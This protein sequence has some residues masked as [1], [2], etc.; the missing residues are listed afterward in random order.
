VHAR[1][2]SIR[3]K[4]LVVVDTPAELRVRLLGGLSVDGV[5]EA[6]FGSRKARLLLKRL[7]IERGR[8]VPSDV[9]IETLWNSDRPA[10]PNDQLGVLVSRLRRVVG[11]ERLVHRASG[12]AL[13]VDWLD[14]DELTTR[15]E[16]AA[17]ASAAGRVSAARS[18][19][20][21]AIALARGGVLPD[22]DGEWLDAERAR[23]DAAI[24]RAHQLVAETALLAGDAEAAAAAAETS[25][26]RDPYDEAALRLLM[27][28]HAA[29]GRPAS[30]LAA[31]VRVRARLAEDLGVDPTPET[32]RLH[33][34]LVLGD[35]TLDARTVH[36]TGKPALFGRDDELAVLDG[37]LARARAGEAVAITVRGEGGIGKSTLVSAWAQSI[38]H[39]A[40]VL[41]CRCDPL[42]RDLPLQPVVDAFARHLD[43]LGPV[44]AEL[45]GDDSPLLAGLLGT[46]AAGTPSTVGTDPEV[47]RSQLFA[48]LLAVVER[49][50]DG[51][52]V[53]IIDDIHHGGTS[54]YEWLSFA[55]R[56]G[57]RLMLVLTSRPDGA[58]LA[59]ADEIVLGPLD[60]E[61]VRS[62]LRD[63]PDASAVDDIVARSAG[64]P[65]FARSLA[66]APGSRTPATIRE[67][68]DRQID[69]LGP[70]AATIR[71][72]S[73]VGAGVDVDL[74]AAVLGTPVGDVLDDLELGC[75]AGLLDEG[76]VGFEFRHELVRDALE[77]SAG[78]ARRAHV[79]RQV[80]RALDRRLPR[81]HLA[82]AV[83]ARLGGDAAL[84]S[85]A[86]VDAARMAFSRFDVGASLDHLDAALALVPSADVYG[87]RARVRLAALDLDGAQHDASEAVALGGGASALEVAAW[88]AYYRRR[89]EEARQ[90]ADAGTEVTGDPALQLSC[91][92]VGGRVRHSQGDLAGAEARLTGDERAAVELRGVTDV[93]LAMVRVHQ[94]RPVEALELAERALARPDRLTHA[95]ALMHGRLGRIMAL[96]Q[97]GRVED[98]L[99]S[100]EELEQ[101]LVRAGA[102]GARFDGITA[103]CRGWLLRNVGCFELADESNERALLAH[104]EQRRLT[105]KGLTEA[106]WVA[107]LDLIDGK[108]MAGDPGAAERLIADLTGLET[109]QGTMAW[110]Q[111]QRLVLARAR[112]RAMSDDQRAAWE[113]AEHVR[114]DAAERGSRRYELLAAAV[115]AG[116]ERDPD[117]AAVDAVIAGLEACAKLEGWRLAADLGRQFGVDRWRRAAERMAAD[118]VANAG[119]H[120]DTASAWID[121]RLTAAW[122]T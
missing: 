79:H 106:Y 19:A 110:H 112:A 93:W 53:V 49:L 61:S 99:V 116:C 119:G 31:Y 111:R 97:L 27:R 6:A 82:V 34:Q 103:N 62:L 51:P 104:A 9:L 24:G 70:A 22:D 11:A 75:R 40:V 105:E 48:S 66:A 91:R 101:M 12:Y 92:A 37:H 114:A 72:A 84:A 47:G 81:D 64:N 33:D 36:A 122:P 80:A 90:Y 71:A 1:R 52:I 109:W 5:D 54:T 43:A 26:V 63:V 86:F 117:I 89:Y 29:A 3:W 115:G 77:Q 96:G 87:L 50:G 13:D 30:G 10:S 68:V 7:A 118:V 4:N 107:H 113:L 44:G 56:R 108:L 98:A 76:I 78:S 121:R 16:E 2:G 14:L 46:A 85:T 83:H 73:I 120:R 88:T 38:A 32:E 21:A 15:V 28:A 100:C 94:G 23:C 95:W 102:A 55:L 41:H 58:A 20:E 18:A 8:S 69:G 42:G 57:R 60:D 67:V 74:L 65:L 17:S 39:T 45:V 59:G 25:L 35:V